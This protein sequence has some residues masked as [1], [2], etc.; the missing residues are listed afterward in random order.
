MEELKEGYSG[1]SREEQLGLAEGWYEKSKLLVKKQLQYEEAIEYAQK[2][3]PIFKKWA[4]WEQCVE[5][6]GQLLQLWLMTHKEEIFDKPLTYIAE[7]IKLCQQ[8]V[9][10]NRPIMV[11]ILILASQVYAEM[12]HF[13]KGL[14]YALESLRINKKFHSKNKLFAQSCYL[15]SLDYQYLDD[16]P[17]GI[18]YG[19]K[20]VLYALKMLKEEKSIGSKEQLISSYVILGTGYYKY[21]D[22]ENALM[23]TRRS[24]VLANEVKKVKKISSHFIAPIYANLAVFY[25]DIGDHQQHVLF[26]RKSFNLLQQEVGEEYYITATRRRNL[27]WALIGNQEQEEG[28]FHLKESLPI[29]QK[30]MPKNH[31][32]IGKGYTYLANYYQIVGD[33]EKCLTF[34]QKALEIY[35]HAYDFNHSDVIETQMFIAESLSHIGEYQ[36]ADKLIVHLIS[37]L[38]NSIRKTDSIIQRFYKKLVEYYLR[39]KDTLK[40]YDAI[41]YIETLMLQESEKEKKESTFFN[42]DHQIFPIVYLKGDVLLQYFQETK[43]IKYL[44]KAVTAYLQATELLDKMKKNYHNEAS[45]LVWNATESDLFKKGII[46]ALTLNRYTPNTQSTALYFSEKAKASL[47]LTSTQSTIAKTAAN[48]SSQLVLAEKQMKLKLTYLNKRIQQLQAKQEKNILQDFESQ[49]LLES[50]DEFFGL[51]QTY[52]S[53]IEQLETDYPDYYQLK[54]DTKTATPTELQSTLAKNQALISYFIGESSIY[55]FVVTLDEFEVEELEKPD[56]FEGMIQEFLQ[57]IHSHDQTTY[58]QL[59]YQ[60]YELLIAPIELHWYNFAEEE[61][62]PQQLIV[63]PHAELSYLPFEALISEQADE[64]TPYE[65]L[66]YLV[67]NY[68]ISYHYSATLWQYAQGNKSERADTEHS[69]VGFAPVYQSENANIEAQEALT[70][71]ANGVRSWATRSEALRSDGSWTPLPHS[72]EEAENIAALFEG[73]GLSSEI[74]LHERAT[75]EEF[76]KAVETSRY[77]LVAA[78]GVVN[79]EKTALSG[80]VFYPNSSEP[81]SRSSTVDKDLIREVETLS[82]AG[83]LDNSWN[84]DG[85]SKNDCILSMEETYPLN[86]QADLVVLSS[87]ESGI[88]KLHKG[89]GMMAVN[90][91]F[92]AAGAKNVISTLFKVYDKPSSLLTQYLF[93]TIL[94]GDSYRAALRKAK[95]QLLEQEGVSPKSWCGFVLIGG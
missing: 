47:L 7:T 80:L 56:D 21:G 10:V 67:Q 3:L 41:S 94:E 46:T 49:S 60:L 70:V 72:K 22:N 34:A 79:D 52:T 76:Q 27:G 14:E 5:V 82:T 92:L 32:E 93:E 85:E 53:F 20:A 57:S 77:L 95:L 11:E 35:K 28:L 90:R 87:C 18:T 81:L 64:N 30:S 78:H 42:F 50:Q 62:T 54:Y 25:N 39:I 58:V 65:E 89:E 15:I 91:G 6:R 48:I 31:F 4:K 61:E 9:P 38:E 37:Q 88:G 45:K 16:Y 83:S 69:F 43:S 36:K 19:E 55:I 13:Y 84:N 26:S 12:G 17:K 66:N 2:A 68:E 8:K 71:A 51:Y 74:Y 63:I 23:N 24:L 40:A 29:I 73:K 1:L 33:Y 75:K 44:Q 86:I 59:A